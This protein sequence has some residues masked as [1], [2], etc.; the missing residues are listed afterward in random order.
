M[1]LHPFSLNR[2]LPIRDD[3][4]VW[5]GLL[6]ALPVGVTLWAALV[7]AAAQHWLR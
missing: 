3:L 4:A 1:P 2:Y 7:I 5:D 6:L